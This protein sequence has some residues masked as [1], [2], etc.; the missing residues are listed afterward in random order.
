MA[1]KVQLDGAMH[2]DVFDLS[3]LLRESHA[4]NA[5]VFPALAPPGVAGLHF[6]SVSDGD[7]RRTWLCAFPHDAEIMD[8]V[9]PKRKR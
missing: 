7:G 2:S 4:E 8:D 3:K 5:T 1:W 6:T 9:L